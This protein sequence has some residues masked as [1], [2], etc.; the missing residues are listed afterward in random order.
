MATKIVSKLLIITLGI[1]LIASCISTYDD[2]K[3]DESFEI[4]EE[5]CIYTVAEQFNTYCTYKPIEQIEDNAND[6]VEVVIESSLHFRIFQTEDLPSWYIHYEVYNYGG[7]VVYSFT[8]SRTGWI[9]YFNDNI[10]EVGV[11]VGTGTSQ[12][13]FY[14]M[15]EDKFSEYFL[16]PFFIK[17]EI[18]A[19]MRLVDDSYWALVVQDIFNPEVFFKAFTFDDFPSNMSPF[20]SIISVEYMEDDTIKVTHY[21]GDDFTKKTVTLSLR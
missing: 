7:E 12:V 13:R 16:S 14:S 5:A 2:P 20:F 18:I 19:E 11:S 3:D 10:L 21:Y 4:F 1:L 8:T 6:N 15:A 9:K 17:D